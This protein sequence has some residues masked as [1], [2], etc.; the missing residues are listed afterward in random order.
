M[1]SLADS[2]GSL[3]AN[4]EQRARDHLDLTAKVRAALDGEEKDHVISASYRD[5]TLIVVADSAAWCPQIRYAQAVLLERLH[6]Q[7]ET[8]FTKVKVKV[9]AKSTE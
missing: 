5:D 9:G 8:Q 6:S 2:L 7:G 4:L 1:K 3:F